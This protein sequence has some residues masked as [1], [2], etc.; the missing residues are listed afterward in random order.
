M[1]YSNLFIS[2]ATLCPLPTPLPGPTPGGGNQSE[3]CTDS[4]RA[5]MHPT[6]MLSW[7]SL[8]L[9]RNGLDTKFGRFFLHSIVAADRPLFTTT[10]SGLLFLFLF[11]S[12]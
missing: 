8:S 1:T 11:I 7:F 6:G 2:G 9:A 4:K 3:T 5:G 10:V 12:C